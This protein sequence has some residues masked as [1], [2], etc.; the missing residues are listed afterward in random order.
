[1]NKK[2]F[3]NIIF[4]S[5]ILTSIVY[6]SCN[7][8][9]DTPPINVVP[10][11]KILTIADI[12]K[13]YN[14]SGNNY[15]FKD[16]FMLFGTITMDDSSGNIYKEAYIQDSTGGINLYKLS[17]A[18]ATKQGENVRINLKNSIV[19]NYNGKMEISFANVLNF[20]KQI[21]VQKQS[22]IM[23][24]EITINQ[25]KTDLYNCKLVKVKD[26]QFIDT[27]LKTTYANKSGTSAQNKT[28]IDSLG[29]TLIVRTSDYAKFAGD[30][31][32]QGS[33]TLV[34]I[35]TKYQRTTATPPVYQLYIRSIAEV[36]MNNPRFNK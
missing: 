21:V 22:P 30:T 35:A 26:V 24:E 7:K 2:Y 4:F 27:E 32:A 19:I 33:G 13:I 36:Q 23:P 34:G 15:V 12:Y 10:Q 5:I 9:L 16:D 6:N 14:D 20:L 28:L 31:V 11:E 8:E 1:M 17:H 18:K 29:N 3:S 25:I